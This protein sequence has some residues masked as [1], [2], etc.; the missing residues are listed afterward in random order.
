MDALVLL[1]LELA[2]AALG[3]LLPVRAL[4]LHAVHQRAL[5]LQLGLV[6]R[7]ELRDD[8]DDAHVVQRQVLLA[9]DHLLARREELERVEQPADPHA[10]RQR[11][12]RVGHDQ[13]RPLVLLVQAQQQVVEPRRQALQRGL[14]LLLPDGRHLAEDQVALQHLH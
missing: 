14:G 8:G 6:E 1:H 4:Q 3:L 9:R 2:L 7:L 10:L 13:V 11:E 5:V 12:R